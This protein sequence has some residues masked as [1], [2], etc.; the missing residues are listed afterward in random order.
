ML[1]D[2]FW[3]W[4]VN[5]LLVSGKRSVCLLDSL[6]VLWGMP[7]CHSRSIFLRKT[8]LFH[9]SV[10][11]RDRLVII[12]FFHPPSS[13]PPEDSGR[14]KGSLGN[15]E[16]ATRHKQL[17]GWLLWQFFIHS[18]FTPR[19][20]GRHLGTSKQELIHFNK[21]P[22]PGGRQASF[23]RSWGHKATVTITHQ[24]TQWQAWAHPHSK[25]CCSFK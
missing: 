7:P 2:W 23:L 19:C 13:P 11:W 1:W 18:V 16:L 5:Y 20:T 10:S 22:L 9:H 3:R 17:H 8:A 14:R 12:P 4:V 25:C 24:E 21:S 6:R 15:H